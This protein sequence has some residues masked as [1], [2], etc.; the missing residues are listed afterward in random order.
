MA[1]KAREESRTGEQEREQKQQGRV[2]VSGRHQAPG[3]TRPGQ[4][5]RQRQWTAKALQTSRV[6]DSAGPRQPLDARP[7]TG[8]AGLSLRG[9][10]QPLGRRA[11][12]GRQRGRLGRGRGR[13]CGR[14]LG[15]SLCPQSCRVGWACGC[16][17]GRGRLVSRSTGGSLRGLKRGCCHCNQ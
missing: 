4:R 14:G 10:H 1:E 3:S 5:D 11:L 6:P 16:A 7:L 8:Q 15:S 13:A 9:E 2:L 12:P 17:G